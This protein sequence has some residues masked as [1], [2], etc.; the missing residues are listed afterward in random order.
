MATENYGDL[1]KSAIA[2]AGTGSEI[3]PDDKYNVKIGTIKHD[4]TKAGKY[5]VGIRLQV[6]DGPHANK[7]TWVNQSFSPESPK[8]ITIFLRLMR[9]LGVPEQAIAAGL[10]PAQLAAYIVV[11]SQ[12]VA[13]IGSHISG[14]NPD[15]TGRKWQDL[16]GFTLSAAAAPAPAPAPAVQEPAVQAAPPAPEAPA[17][18][19]QVSA[20]VAAPPLPVQP[21]A[22]APG[23]V[24]A[25]F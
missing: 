6:L 2:E 4:T 23:Q 14:T 19:P 18:Q 11:G 1:Y 3:L 24:P 15:G 12:G 10:P 25:P 22:V 8:A 20:P 16:K 9:E 13:D 17:V 7:S 21:G 5:K